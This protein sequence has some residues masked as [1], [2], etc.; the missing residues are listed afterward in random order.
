MLPAHREEGRDTGRARG[1]LAQLCSK[2]LSGVKQEKIVTGSWRIQG[3][4]LHFGDLR[5]LWVNVYFPTD[6]RICNFDEAE[7]LNVQSELKQVLDR[8]GH[9]VFVF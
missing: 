4:I 8:G 6:P 1:G 5:L 2:D 7:L 3:Q 9:I